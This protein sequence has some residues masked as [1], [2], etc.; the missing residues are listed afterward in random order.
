MQ[1]RERV[2]C[3]CNQPFKGCTCPGE[4]ISGII[5]CLSCGYETDHVGDVGGFWF[6]HGCV[7]MYLRQWNV[8]PP[9]VRK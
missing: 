3:D 9:S 4:W 5:E 8:S 1:V 2:C 7:G 6:C